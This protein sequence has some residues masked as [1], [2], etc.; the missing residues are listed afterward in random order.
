MAEAARRIGH[1]RSGACGVPAAAALWVPPPQAAHLG[2]SHTLVGFYA[3]ITVVFQ[4]ATTHGIFRIRISVPVQTLRTLRNVRVSPLQTPVCFNGCLWRTAACR[5]WL[6]LRSPARLP[7][8]HSRPFLSNHSPTQRLRPAAVWLLPGPQWSSA[9]SCAWCLS[10]SSA[11]PSFPGLFDL[12]F[13][14]V[15]TLACR[16]RGARLST[17]FACWR[18]ARPLA[19]CRCSAR[20]TYSSRTVP[21]RNTL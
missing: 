4:T 18:R 11:P 15:S 6:S 7:M 1:Q 12:F 19:G 9:T 14:P 17:G 8:R 5:L 13:E 10:A 16:K 21:K 3:A 20:P 2:V